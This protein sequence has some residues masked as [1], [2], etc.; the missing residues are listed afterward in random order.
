LSKD[1]GLNQGALL[2]EELQGWLLD[3]EEDEV[4]LAKGAYAI[5]PLTH[6]L[7]FSFCVRGSHGAGDT[8]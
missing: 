1:G 8:I 6:S 2:G 5:L 7:S 4:T 3:G